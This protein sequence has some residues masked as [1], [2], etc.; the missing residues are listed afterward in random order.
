MSVTAVAVEAWSNRHNASGLRFTQF[1]S[2]VA[3]LSIWRSVRTDSHT[4]ATAISPVYGSP[5]LPCCPNRTSPPVMAVSSPIAVGAVVCVAVSVDETIL[6]P[7]G[8]TLPA[9]LV[10]AISAHPS[11][12]W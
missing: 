1:W 2:E 5:P 8:A 10:I 9:A 4:P 6:W 7:R 12:A 11:L 3:R